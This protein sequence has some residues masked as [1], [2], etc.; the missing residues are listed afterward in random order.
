LS[1]PGKKRSR[2]AKPRI[3][4]LLFLPVGC[5]GRLG[6]PLFGKEGTG[7]ISGVTDGFRYSKKSPLIPRSCEKIAEI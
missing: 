5:G 7:E 4:T 3:L 1:Q 2:S 6:F